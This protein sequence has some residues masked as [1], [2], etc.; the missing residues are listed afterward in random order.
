M[1]V[2]HKNQQCDQPQRG[3][4]REKERERDDRDRDRV[5]DRDRDR[6]R[7]THEVDVGRVDGRGQEL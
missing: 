4:A 3:E 2:Q 1:T 6:D 5:R 7:E